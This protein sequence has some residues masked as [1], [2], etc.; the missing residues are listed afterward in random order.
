[1]HNNLIGNQMKNPRNGSK[2]RNF[3]KRHIK[4]NC[5]QCGSKHRLQLHH[6]IPID[7]NM[8]LMFDLDNIKTLCEKCHKIVHSKRKPKVSVFISH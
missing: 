1:V 2:Y 8:A 4:A 6:I 5:E 7:E 3:V